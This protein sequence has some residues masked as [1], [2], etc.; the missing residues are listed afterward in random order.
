MCPIFK[1]KDPTDIHNY[2]PITVLNTDYKI[3]T[4]ALSLKLTEVAPTIIHQDQAGFMPG[5]QIL[6]QI[7]LAR[8]FVE[9]AEADLK[10]GAIIALD[11]EKAYDRVSHRYLWKTMEAF[12]LPRGFINTV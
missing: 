3:F 11:Q 7:L 2:R 10:N 1:K 6:D 9:Y 12:N 5:Q 4:K 8:V